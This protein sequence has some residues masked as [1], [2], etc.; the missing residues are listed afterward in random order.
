MVS[1]LHR[2]YLRARFHR[3]LRRHLGDFFLSGPLHL[4]SRIFS[5]MQWTARTRM[6]RTRICRLSFQF[7]RLVRLHDLLV[8]HCLV[9]DLLEYG[10]VA[11]PSTCSSRPSSLP[12]DLFGGGPASSALTQPAYRIY[13]TIRPH[14][15]TRSL[16]PRAVV[17]PVDWN[18]GK[19][20]RRQPMVALLDL[21]R[22]T[23]LPRL[24]AVWIRATT[25]C[26]P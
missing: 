14:H 10:A 12:P 18:V 2:G 25:T 7:L 21:H 8:K 6:P 16:T 9:L 1:R 5:M 23:R 26:R 3:L 19:S 24:R 15:G 11:L 17:P 4:A 13:L 20:R 22:A